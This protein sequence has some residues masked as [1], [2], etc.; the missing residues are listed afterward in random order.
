MNV[1]EEIKKLN[2]PIDRYVVIGGSSLAVRGIRE[3]EDI[4]LVVSKDLLEEYKQKEGWHTHPRLDT[5]KEPGLTNGPVEMYP[6]IGY[7]V[8]DSFEE[9][10]SR[11]DIVEGIPVASLEDIIRIKETYK[12]EKDLRDIELIKT[13]IASL[14]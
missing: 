4:D 14:K 10:I 6:D 3:T 13:Y 7:G 8:E 1:I 9:M 2:L 12:R 11:A 5:T